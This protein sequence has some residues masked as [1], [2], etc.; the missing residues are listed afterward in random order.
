M[1][2]DSSMKEGCDNMSEQENRAAAQAQDAKADKKV[3]TKTE[4]KARLPPRRRTKSPTG[5]SVG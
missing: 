2:G 4:K 3:E 5:S 1:G